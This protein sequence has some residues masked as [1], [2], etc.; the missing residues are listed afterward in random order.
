MNVN[1]LLSVR[2]PY[3]ATGARGSGVSDR[4]PIVALEWIAS[5]RMT[6]D[7]NR[8]TVQATPTLTASSDGS[9]RASS[10]SL[11]ATE[12]LRC[13]STVRAMWL[14]KEA[15]QIRRFTQGVVSSPFA[16]SAWRDRAGQRLPRSRK[17][18]NY[19]PAPCGAIWI[20]SAYTMMRA[21]GTLSGDPTLWMI[22]C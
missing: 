2:E 21:C 6:R 13:R 18:R 19:S 14:R 4:R 11:R 22:S 3:G 16:H 9:E 10:M 5:C 20:H 1:V 15:L 8:E 17:K 12:Y 7:A